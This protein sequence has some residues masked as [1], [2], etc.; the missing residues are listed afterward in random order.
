MAN[1]LGAVWDPIRAAHI[2]KHVIYR[3]GRM[4]QAQSETTRYRTSAHMVG[5]RAGAFRSSA[6]D[7]QAVCLRCQERSSDQA[8]GRWGRCLWHLFAGIWFMAALPFRLIFWIIAWM[9]RVTA[10]VLGFSLMVVGIALWAGPLFF[11]GIP[12]FLVG[13]V[14]TLRCLD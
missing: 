11:I 1:T 8:H 14:V 10:V 3:D 9:G 12:L 2:N 13:L 4:K 5:W 7:R 6:P